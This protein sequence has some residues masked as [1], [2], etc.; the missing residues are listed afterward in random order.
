VTFGRE[1]RVAA[2]VAALFVA[3]YVAM[4]AAFAAPTGGFSSATIGLRDLG[5]PYFSQNWNV[6]APNILKTNITM[7]V[8]AQWRGD[9]GELVRGGWFSATELELNAVAGQMLPSRAIKQSWNLI[10]AY[11]RRYLELNS[12]QRDYVRNTFI[13]RPGST[14]IARPHDE[15]LA[16]L[17]ALGDNREAVTR[18]LRYD[19]VVT[20]YASYLATAYFGEQIER[21]RW[22]IVYQR[23]NTFEQRHSSRQ[24][25]DVRWRAFGWRQADDLIR[26]DSLA[27]FELLVER[28][29]GGAS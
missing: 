2:G 25:F 19:S 26:P 5:R 14:F 12:E 4:S 17:G 22:R 10:Q 27:A 15:L 11:N 8:D 20:E 21:V 28:G 23:P 7:E 13:D 9:S 1:Q 18:L 29:G 24:Q 16:D 6:F 3:L